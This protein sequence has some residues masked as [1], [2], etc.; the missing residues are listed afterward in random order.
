MIRLTIR[1]GKQQTIEEV[2]D[3]CK[4]KVRDLTVDDIMVKPKALSGVIVKDT[5]GNEVT[6][7]EPREKCYCEHCSHD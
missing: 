4:C 3:H 6:R 7:T 2:C 1:K 5:N